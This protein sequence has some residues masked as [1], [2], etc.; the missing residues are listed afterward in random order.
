MNSNMRQRGRIA[1]EVVLGPSAEQKVQTVQTSA[2]ANVVPRQNGNLP[3]PKI[4]NKFV[5]F[6][7]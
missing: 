5:S 2:T 1:V 6:P 4:A 3:V 7:Q